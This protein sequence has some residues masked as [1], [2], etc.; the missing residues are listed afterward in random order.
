[1]AYALTRSTDQSGTDKSCISANGATN[2][3]TCG[4]IPALSILTQNMEINWA[5]DSACQGSDTLN[6][7]STGPI[8]IQKEV[9]GVLV[10]VAANDCA[11][12]SVYKLQAVGNPVAAFKMTLPGAGA[13]FSGL[14]TNSILV[15]GSSTTASTPGGAGFAFT[16]PATNKNQLE[17]DSGSAQTGSDPIV[18]MKGSSGANDF[19]LIKEPFANGDIGVVFGDWTSNGSPII[20][21]DGSGGLQISSRTNGRTNLTLR[22][23]TSF[24]QHAGGSPIDNPPSIASGFGTG[25]AL[26]NASDVS[27]RINVGA[28]GAAASGVINFGRA[29]NNAP[30]C[31]ANDENTKVLVQASATTTQLTLSSASAWTA[32]DKLTWICFGQ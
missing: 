9:A 3:H 12:N 11:A 5:T 28:G 4:L 21:P 16:H 8:P 17:L 30:A 23:D 6:I 20:G 13:G 29:Y 10:N 18:A 15:G 26:V 25:P 14:T 2:T 7:N 22:A 1:M 27:G 31:V 19:A 24:T 32:S